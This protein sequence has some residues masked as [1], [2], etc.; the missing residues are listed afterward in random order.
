[1][2]VKK[3]KQKQKQKNKKKPLK[4]DVFSTPD[5]SFFG[6]YHHPLGRDKLLIPHSERGGPRKHISKCIALSQL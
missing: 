2:Q 6:F 5:K 1:M 4:V 3:T